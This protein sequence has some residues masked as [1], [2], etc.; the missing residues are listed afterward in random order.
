MTVYFAAIG[1]G[2]ILVQPGLHQRLTLVLGHPT[3]APGRPR[4]DALGHRPRPAASQRVAIGRAARAWIA[5]GAVVAGITT[6]L[7]FA[8]GLIERIA[9]SISAGGGLRAHRRRGRLRPRLR[10]PL[11]ARLVPPR[12]SRSMWPSTALRSSRARALRTVIG[13]GAREP[14][15]PEP[16]LCADV[17]VAICG[18]LPSGAAWLPGRTSGWHLVAD[19]DVRSPR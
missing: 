1:L 10:L 19:A 3:S 2:Y 15:G 13:L 12:R 16:G 18:T 11:G 9:A 17:V 8:V 5:I 4:L 14:G 6:A 7:L